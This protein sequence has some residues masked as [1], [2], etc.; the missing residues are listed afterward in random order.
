MVRL[1]VFALP[2]LGPPRT[3]NIVGSDILHIGGAGSNIIILNSA[4]AA[5]DLFDKRSWMYSSRHV[6][7]SCFTA[8]PI[9]YS[10][11]PLGP[12]FPSWILWAT[13]TFSLVW[14]MAKH[15]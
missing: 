8:I 6:Q 7:M 3:H 15:G 4:D 10:L 9:N 2:T 14:L 11:F 12:D 1:P 5:V 13:H